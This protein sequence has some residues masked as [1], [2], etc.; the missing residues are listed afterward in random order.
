MLASEGRAIPRRAVELAARMARRSG[1]A[2]HVLS[3]ARIWGTSLGFPHPALMPNRREWQQQRDRVAE[4]VAALER[5]K[6]SASGQVL[7]TR[8]AAKRILEEAR[9][10]RVDAIVMAADPPRH[11][12]FADM[13]WS[14]EP[15][16]VRRLAPVPVY[17]V[18][19]APRPK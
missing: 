13:A 16:R 10:R 6:L 18:L 15:Y 3:V 17:L 1:A 9:R 5:H 19:E 14:Q 12:L 2:V 11:W 8:Q 4:A 7:G